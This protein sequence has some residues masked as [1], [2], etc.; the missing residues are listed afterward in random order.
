MVTSTDGAVTTRPPP[1]PRRI[2]AT[3]WSSTRRTA[4]RNTARL[5]PYR[6][7]QFGLGPEHDPLGPTGRGDVRDDPVGHRGGQLAAIALALTMG[8][9]GDVDVTDRRG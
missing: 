5:M 6:W 7:Q 9:V 1:G 2:R 3:F 8:S 4:S